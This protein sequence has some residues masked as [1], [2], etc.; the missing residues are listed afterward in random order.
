MIDKRDSK[1]C[2]STSVNSAL[3]HNYS[4]GWRNVDP[5]YRVGGGGSGRGS[6]FFVTYIRKALQSAQITL[7]KK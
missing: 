1:K 4:K 2:H 3:V 7:T 5:V 6:K